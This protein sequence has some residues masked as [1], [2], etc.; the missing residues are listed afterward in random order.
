MRI[1]ILMR[2]KYNDF[3]SRIEYIEKLLIFDEYSKYK[4]IR[5]VLI[6]KYK[7]QL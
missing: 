4:D 3:K 2:K 6:P 5:K 7:Y 1:K